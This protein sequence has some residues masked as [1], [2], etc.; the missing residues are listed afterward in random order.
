MYNGQLRCMGD[1]CMTGYYYNGGSCTGN[2][3]PTYFTTQSD[4]LPVRFYYR[5]PK[6]P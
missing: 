4:S 1:G 6:S 5:E 2:F 3:S